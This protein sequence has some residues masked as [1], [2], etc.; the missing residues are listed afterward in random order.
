MTVFFAAMSGLIH[1]YI[2]CLES[3]LWGRPKTNRTFGMS[4]EMAE[5][6][7]LFAFNQGFYNLFL[8]GAVIAGLGMG[9]ESAAGKTLLAYAL[10]SMLLAALVLIF[11]NRK[12]WRASL[13]QGVPP[14]LAL[15]FLALS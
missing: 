8:S 3:L 6:N 11:S 15:L 12:L 7:R 13:I 5:Y 2:F 10:I 4:P 1:V 14:L 9:V